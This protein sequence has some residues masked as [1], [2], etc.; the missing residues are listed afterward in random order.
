MGVG[1]AGEEASVK[2]LQILQSNIYVA[3]MHG[4]RLLDAWW[5]LVLINAAHCISWK[6]EVHIGH[7][8]VTSSLVL[9]PK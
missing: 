9:T 1:I 8:I 4:D 2:M 5:L 6:P 3:K 7:E